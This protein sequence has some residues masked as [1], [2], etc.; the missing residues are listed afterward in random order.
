MTVPYSRAIATQGGFLWLV[1]ILLPRWRGSIYRHVWKEMILFIILY[2]STSAIYWF[3]LSDKYKI[4][5]EEVVIYCSKMSS[6]LPVTTLLGFFVTSVFKRWWAI[7]RNIPW[8]DQTA[9]LT[10]SFIGGQDKESMKIRQTV[11]RNVNVVIAMT[12]KK[13][14]PSVRKKYPTLR[15]L[16]VKTLSLNSYQLSHCVP[17]L[18]LIILAGYLTAEETLIIENLRSRSSVDMTYVPIVWACKTVDKAQN[19]EYIA[20][21]HNKIDLM[22]EILAIQSK[23]MELSHWATCA[24]P[25]AYSQVVTIV[26]YF[27]YLSS[28]VGGQG[29]DPK[30]Q[31]EGYGR[32]YFPIFTLLQIFFYIGWLKVAESFT[33]PFGDDDDDFEFLELL[34]RHRQMSKMLSEQKPGTLPQ[35]ISTLDLHGAAES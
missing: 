19:D 20:S 2:Y 5:F 1:W 25:L 13:L 14:S 30:R 32:V 29:L 31:H 24:I 9:I 18:I 26:V 34:K 22:T 28:V 16:L 27:F 10:T 35:A 17:P 12:F 3:A 7:F 21:T 15:S 6:S 33:N 8:P 11:I 4:I 23:C